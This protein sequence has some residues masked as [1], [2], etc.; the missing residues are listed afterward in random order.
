MTTKLIVSNKT[1]QALDLLTEAKMSSLNIKLAMLKSRFNKLTEDRLVFDILKDDDAKKELNEINL[2]ILELVDKIE[3]RPAETASESATVVPPTTVM[4]SEREDKINRMRMIVIALLAI[5]AGGVYFF[6]NSE[7]SIP[8]DTTVLSDTV[9]LGIKGVFS[10]D[11]NTRKKS[12]QKFLE[13]YLNEPK[14]VKRLIDMATARID[15][16]KGCI[17]AL[18]ILDRVPIETL[19]GYRTELLEFLDLVD[20]QGGR[21]QAKAK[22]R[23]IRTKIG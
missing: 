17:N 23:E 12:V 14:A 6:M 20:Q 19:L 3:E 7:P 22:A 11:E 2:A 16:P 10:E 5:I 13:N 21:A 8:Q 1:D 18:F 4:P 15:N 9:V